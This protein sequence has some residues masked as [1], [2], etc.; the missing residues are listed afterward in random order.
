M[1]DDKDRQ[2]A[3]L[4]IIRKDTRDEIKQRIEQR[5]KYSVQLTI[6][7]GLIVSVSFAN[8]HF[9]K[10][11]IAAPLVSIYFTMLILYSYKIHTTLAAYLRNEIE[12]TLALLCGTDSKKELETYYKEDAHK[13]PGIR[14]QFFLWALW[15]VCLVSLSYLWCK[16]RVGF[17]TVLIIT[18]LIYII[19]SVFITCKFRENN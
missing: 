14:R 1:G 16:E 8:A 2:I 4:E 10:V 18:S 3:H 19:A 15:V 6:A 9:G 11:M 13:I 5:D 7:L 12:P 17:E